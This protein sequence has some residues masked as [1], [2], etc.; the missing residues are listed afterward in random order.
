MVFSDVFQIDP[1]ALEEYGAFNIS[2]FV[3]LPLFIDP[4]LLFCSPKPEYQELH[5]K[6]IDYLKFL[7][8]MSST[9]HVS[10]GHLEAWYKFPEVQQNWFGFCVDGNHGRGL[11]SHFASSLNNNLGSLFNDFGTE[12]ITSGSHL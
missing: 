2:L 1:N 4:F 7:R 10:K 12:S 5:G 8:D 3:E 6:I 9:E 11:G